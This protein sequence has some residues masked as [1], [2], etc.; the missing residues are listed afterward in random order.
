M[1]ITE[2]LLSESSHF[3]T[4]KCPHCGGK[5]VSESLVSEKKDSC[6]YKVKSRYKVWPSAYASGALVKCRKKGA[7]NWGKKTENIVNSDLNKVVS[8]ITENLH[9]W[10][11]EKWVRFGPDGKIKGDCAR[12][13]EREGKPKCLP[14][15]KAHSLSKK[16]R[17]SAAS[18]KRREDPNPERSGAAI[19][20]ATKKKTNSVAEQLKQ[21]GIAEGTVQTFAGK[22]PMS[23]KSPK[24]GTPTMMIVTS[25]GSRYLI[26]SDGMVLRNKS[27]HANTG[28]EDQ[29]LKSW[30]DAIEFYDPAEQPGGATFPMS[31][32][33]AVEKRLP[34]TLSKTQDGKRALLI[35]DRSQWRVAKISDIYKYVATQDAPI[36]A[37]YSKTPKL[38]WNVLDYTMGP[39]KALKS[40]HPGSPVTHGIALG[41]QG[42]AEDYSNTTFNIA[43]KK[44]TIEANA[45]E[46]MKC[47]PATQDIKLNLANR[48]TAI[49]EYGYGPL[50]PDLPN[51]KFWMK[52][53]DEWNLDS[54][55]DAQQS[56]CGNCAAFDQRQ[57]TL[58]CIATGIDQDTP[59]DAEA[60]INA[61]DLGYCKF[62]KFKCASRRTC[63]A[64][65]SGGP[66]TD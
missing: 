31:V 43:T 19:N 32:A 56:L 34:V 55:K 4:E 9:K 66:L 39:N 53:V 64:W 38:N 10:F 46:T 40:V 59:Q 20:V 22:D 65:V 47:P 26:T 48:Q 52:K 50:N 2:L 17:A 37:T 44:K 36:V 21:Q 7:K 41:K 45:H 1:K 15:S 13:N 3:K 29:G 63:D 30:S 61:G 18:R 25:Q 51:T 60:T 14:Q 12:G 62:L 49:D 6:Y 16:E 35:Y 57:D 58:N 27:F 8:E 23:F 28:G 54:V 33:K 24:G 5:L 42:V 11:K